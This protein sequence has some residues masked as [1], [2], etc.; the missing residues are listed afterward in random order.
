[1]TWAGSTH[2]CV[3]PTRLSGW[4]CT[5]ESAAEAKSLAGKVNRVPRS[6][7]GLTEQQKGDS[8]RQ[9]LLWFR[10]W[11]GRALSCCS[12]LLRDFLH[13]SHFSNLRGLCRLS[14]T[15]FVIYFCSLEFT[16]KLR[17]PACFVFAGFRP[18]HLRAHLVGRFRLLWIRVH[19][20]A[21]TDPPCRP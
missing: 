9:N 12:R 2:I 19:S 13:V 3:H 20:D 11:I 17:L 6:R 21:R 10:I 16:L 1:M 5:A 15:A 14:H 4:T 18:L 8:E 7:R